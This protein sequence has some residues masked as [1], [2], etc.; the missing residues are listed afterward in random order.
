MKVLSLIFLFFLS[1]ISFAQSTASHY[2]IINPGGHKGQIRSLLVTNDKK[3]IVTG[4]YDKTIKVWDIESGEQSREILS[5]IGTGSEGMIYEMALS[6]DDKL[7][8]VGGWFGD[9]QGRTEN[10]GDIRVFEFA[11]G[12]LLYVLKGHINVIHALEFTEDNKSL[13]SADA[14]GDL[15]LWDLTTKKVIRKYNATDKNLDLNKF[16]DDVQSISA[17]KNRFVTTDRYGRIKLWNI[18]KKDTLR[19]DHYYEQIPADYAEYSPDGKWIVAVVDTFFTVYDAE[20]KPIAE[21]TSK[22]GLVIA[23]FSPDSK[24]IAFGATGRGDERECDILAL[25]GDAWVDYASFSDIDNYIPNFDV[26]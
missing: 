3:Y 15:W 18:D 2:L 20:L 11:T 16:S 13:L 4:S 17:S 6:S 10:L 21:G 19:C 1:S 22:Y 25:E 12:K 9:T 14:E 8:A 24:K 23:K 5:Q 7:L 26:R